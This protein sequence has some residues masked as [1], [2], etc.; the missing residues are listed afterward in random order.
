MSKLPVLDLSQFENKSDAADFYVRKFSKHLSEN[1]HNISVPH[2][3]NFYLTLLVT[4][5]NG[6][7]E[8]D[9]K[10][11]DVRSGSVFFLNPGQTHYWEFS[12]D[13]EGIIFLHTAPFYNLQFKMRSLAT[14]PFFYS[15]RNT[16]C[17]QLDPLE[18]QE[19]SVQF[20]RLLREHQGEEPDREAKISNLVDAIY[21]DL[22][23]LYLKQPGAVLQ[24]QNQRADR[25]KLLEELIEQHYR[26][27]KYAQFYADRLFLSL[28]QLNRICKQALNQ[29][30]TELIHQRVMLEAK[31][32]LTH[33]DLSLVELASYLGYEE[34]AYFSRIFKKHSGVN[35]LAFR[36]VW[37]A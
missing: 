14:F 7:H 12:A 28:K 26:T 20:D 23:R 27:E 33:S 24:L 10:R 22:S 17:L 1:H 30:C 21:I 15:V 6:F 19:I 29:S 8:V 32:L 5:G 31:R 16:A 35:P 9:F 37:R 2:K 4:A 18:F 13:I 25:I 36:S 11:Y 3:H 34:Y